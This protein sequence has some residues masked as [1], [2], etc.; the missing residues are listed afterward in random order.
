MAIWASPRSRTSSYCC[1]CQLASS[2]SSPRKLVFWFRP[3]PPTRSIAHHFCED[4]SKDTIPL[5]HL[6][7]VASATTNMTRR[8][9]AQCKQLPCLVLLLVPASSM[10]STS[11][12]SR[13]PTRMC[14]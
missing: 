5:L 9:E 4:E 14:A 8:F 1:S 13:T 2:S 10:P 7:S 11:S 12:S 3:Q 6:Q